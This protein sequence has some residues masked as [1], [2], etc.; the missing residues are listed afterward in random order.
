MAFAIR[1]FPLITALAFP[2]SP[3]AKAQSDG[4]E[5]I[6]LKLAALPASGGEV[7]IPAG[8]YT[9]R[10]PIVMDSDYQRLRGEGDVTLRLADHANA[11]VI[12]MGEVHTPPKAVIGLVVSD[13][14]IDG[15]R[16]NQDIE[17]WGGDCDSGHTAFIRNNGITVR[18]ALHARILNVFITGPRSGGVVTERNTVS[19]LIDGL[20]VTDSYF[21][22]FA[23][24]QT[25][26]SILQ[27]LHFYDNRAAGISLDID[28]NHN[29][30]R[31]ARLERNGDVG[32]FM[33]HSSHNLFDRVVAT[34]SGSHGVFAAFVEDESTCPNHN[35]FRDFS[36]IGSAGAGF[37]LN[38]AC[39]GNRLTGNAL[40]SRN[41]GGCIAEGSPV[42]L[43]I[44]GALTCED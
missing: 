39:V 33:R 38:N 2:F 15:N 18:H 41:R 25:Y 13:L 3:S 16:R 19:L 11:P 27:N 8:V 20:T 26:H 28:F 35:E 12:I 21:D 6:R 17:C 1:F 9:C 37:R 14:K 10:A 29:T 7:V 42:R 4:C 34:E 36:A 22:G 24:Y 30:I 23:G 5:F 40:F 43:G 44:E 32:I 31:Q